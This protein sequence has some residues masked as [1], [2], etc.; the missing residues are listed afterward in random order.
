MFRV[1]TLR[2]VI[3]AQGMIVWEEDRKRRPG[4]ID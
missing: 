2:R 1:L 4:P 3:V